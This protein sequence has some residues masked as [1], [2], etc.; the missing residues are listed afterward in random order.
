MWVH[1]F[2][3]CALALL[4]DDHRSLLECQMRYREI[5]QR[6]RTMLA[7]ISLNR[8]KRVAHEHM[9]SNYL[10]HYSNT[11]RMVG[12]FNLEH[13]GGLHKLISNHLH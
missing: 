12:W 2:A 3:M 10:S 8:R 5:N 1:N 7:N 9:I 4:L 6:T 13:K 11:Y